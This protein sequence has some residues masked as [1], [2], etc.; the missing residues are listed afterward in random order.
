[1]RRVVEHA[2]LIGHGTA[3]TYAP[4]PNGDANAGFDGTR[5][6]LVDR[7]PQGDSDASWIRLLIGD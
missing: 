7:L 1:M 6:A 2:H 4:I 3:L 5:V